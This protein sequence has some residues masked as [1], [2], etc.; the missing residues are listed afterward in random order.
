MTSRHTGAASVRAAA[1]VLSFS[2]WAPSIA[3]FELVV[4]LNSPLNPDSS[5]LGAWGYLL[6]IMQTYQHL[7][8]L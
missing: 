1:S 8:P 7:Y 3:E 4:Q 5:L 6:Y 2:A